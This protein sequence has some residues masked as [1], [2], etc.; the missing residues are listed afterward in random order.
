MGLTRFVGALVAAGCLLAAGACHKDGPRDLATVKMHH[1]KDGKYAFYNT[2]NGGWYWYVPTTPGGSPTS[3]TGSWQVGT[4]PTAASIADEV[5]QFALT[6][7]ETAGAPEAPGSVAW[8]GGDHPT[9]VAEAE[10]TGD[11]HSI[12]GPTEATPSVPAEASAPAD[13]GGGGGGDAGGGG[14]GE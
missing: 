3:G 6:I 14:G 5:D 2:T 9:Q 10:A 11:S 13:T 7:A 4:A 1:L 8:A 12:A